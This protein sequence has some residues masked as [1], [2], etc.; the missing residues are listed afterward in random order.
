LYLA[1]GL[2]LQK[3]LGLLGIFLNQTLFL[4][5][6]SVW[7][8]SSFEA[9]WE[10]W[11]IW[12]RPSLRE[13]VLVVALTLVVSTAID[14]LVYLQDSFWPLP[15]TVERFYED[16]VTFKGAWE[17]PLKIVVLAVTP[18]FAEEIF[19]R[20]IL[21]PSWT[22]RFGNGVGLVLTALAFAFAHGNPW[23]FHFYFIL[24]L[25]LGWLLKWRDNLWLPILAHLV[26]NLWALL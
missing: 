5:L 14:L 26:N 24:G 21:Q 20:G 11:E 1:S 17:S 22:H 2:F 10:E 25:Y 7:I 4:F 9:P 8:A 12:K 3:N 23:H 19:F 6:P 13:I 18:A 16:L 15:D